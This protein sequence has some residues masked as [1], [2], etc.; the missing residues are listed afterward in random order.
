MTR[1]SGS[2]AC[3]A[4]ALL[5]IAAL[6]GQS[7]WRSCPPMRP[8]PQPS[9][10]PLDIDSRAI[11][12]DAKAG[13]DAAEGTIKAP[14]KTL[15][16]AITK[17][18]PG[19]T[20]YLRGGVYYERVAIRLVGTKDMPITIRSFPGELAVIDGGY[21]EFDEEPEKCWEP[22]PNVPGEY[23]S[24][25]TYPEL[26]ED[27]GVVPIHE[28][29]PDHPRLRFGPAAKV[30]AALGVP[31][32]IYGSGYFSCAVKV[33]GNF[34]DSMVPL[35]GYFN[36]DDL[37]ADDPQVKR[38]PH[39]YVGPGLWFDAKTNRIHG[40]FA[41]TALA[42]LGDLNYRGETDPRQ[43]RLVIGGPRVVVHIEGSKHLKLHGIAIRGTRS[44]TLN[45][46]SSTDVEV[47]HAALYGGAPAL[48]VRS[49]ERFRLTHSALRGVCAPWSTR[50]SEKYHG[51][52]CYLFIGDGAAPQNRDVEIANCEFTDN[53]DGAV[54]GTIDALRFHRNFFD[55]F[56]DDGLYLTTD[57]PAG[58]DVR[59]YQN[60]LSRAF[61]ALSYAGS[62]KDQ[63][64]KEVHVFR[65]VFDLREGIADPTG[66][67]VARTCGDHGSP[68]WKPMRFYHNTVLLA[69]TPWR[70]YYGGGLA[71][72]IANSKRFVLNNIFYHEKGV[73][74]FAIEPNGEQL[75]D[76]NLHWSRD[77]KEAKPGD[78]LT[79]GRTPLRKMPNWFEDS[80]KSYPPGWT[81]NDV[82]ADPKFTC[83]APSDFRIAAG[84]PAIDAGVP[85]PKDWIDPL[86]EE[87]KP[88]I[89]ALPAGIDEWKVGIDGRFS[90]S[91]TGP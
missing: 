31:R 88:D 40:K 80:K 68:V 56:N 91:G 41:H 53:H 6:A 86:R 76:G 7:Q 72:A 54:V 36:R 51:I 44:R 18:Q 3:A 42:H 32:G 78:F 24:T 52:S 46:E 74:G 65:N 12:A 26:A 8:L 50:A 4:L 82:F 59:I 27:S 57:M 71:K 81:G 47:D 79:K 10:V 70:N 43:L 9:K 83:F 17:L 39:E 1:L 21:R 45:V 64:G 37:P 67:S 23:R 90:A 2:A 63:E 55:N 30:D 34:A 60:Y 25:R 62:G 48:Q 85:V 66:F 87:G 19:D 58:R 28:N 20:L 13:N 61:T 49:V 69:E 11:F 14:W 29:N 73:P 89:G 75:H 16:H 22:V 38:R 84:S 33:L 35:H 77:V 5:P 15:R